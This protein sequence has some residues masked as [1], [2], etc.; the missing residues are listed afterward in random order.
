M[1]SGE[2]LVRSIYTLTFMYHKNFGIQ[3]MREIPIHCSKFHIDTSF[4]GHAEV[5]SSGIAAD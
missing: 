2:L 4:Y 5:N 3:Y 1:V